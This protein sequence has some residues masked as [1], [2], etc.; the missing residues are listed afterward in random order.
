M[1]TL[2]SI[3]YGSAVNGTAYDVTAYERTPS[4]SDAPDPLNPYV[5]ATDEVEVSGG[6]L[7]VK[8]G[9]DSN[10]SLAG[11]SFGGFGDLEDGFWDAT[12]GCAAVD[13]IFTSGALNDVNI[14]PLMLVQKNELHPD[15]P[16]PLR[17]VLEDNLDS[18]QTFNL[19]VGGQGW[20]GD[21]EDT[22]INFD[23]AELE[24]I[25][26]TV[27]V[28]WQ[29]GT[30]TL[31]GSPPSITDVAHDGF[32]RVYW[33]GVL[34][35]E[36]TGLDLYISD[37]QGG[38][39]WANG[40]SV[41][42]S[43]LMGTV[44][45]VRVANTLCGSSRNLLTGSGHTVSGSD[46]LMSGSMGTL[47]GDLAVLHNL[48][49]TPRTRTK[50]RYFGVFAD[51]IELDADT[52]SIPGFSASVA[53]GSIT[54][55][56]IQDVSAASRLL[57]RG[58]AAG[59]GDVQE[60]SLGTGLT[61][62]GTSLAASGDGSVRAVKTA[63][64]TKNND[65]AIANDPHLVFAAP[66]ATGSWFFEAFL[67]WEGNSTAADIK[68]GWSFPSGAFIWWGPEVH[69]TTN[70]WA[71]VASGTTPATIL[72]E[73][74]VLAIGS[75]T[76]AGFHLTKLAGWFITNGTSG[77]FNLQWAQNSATAV[78]SRLLLHSFLRVSPQLN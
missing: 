16:Y 14:G 76:G 34:I 54:Y 33:H 41:G 17:L 49:A 2:L 10:W 53:D 71:P 19:R 35:L 27:R 26:T 74:T 13:Y 31:S 46:N 12:Q 6:L 39:N 36:L 18:P 37:D 70:Y 68:I 44:S 64:T 8:D 66:A 75:P 3:A 11:V 22:S 55:A 38:P 48:D 73:T 52:V 47:I 15:S 77:N 65:A 25:A 45:S 21:I 43:G 40:F 9:N 50:S 29:C 57:G 67:V 5:V 69:G 7:T 56:K 28:E 78:N 20:D 4:G 60:I 61:M 32:I 58:S 62:T 30:A 51:E 63:T 24:D 42:Y 1:A 59:A 23:R 72:I